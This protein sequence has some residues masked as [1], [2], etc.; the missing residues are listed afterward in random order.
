[1]KCSSAWSHPPTCVMMAMAT[2]PYSRCATAEA[3]ASG[4]VRTSDIIAPAATV[5]ASPTTAFSCKATL[6]LIAS[7]SHGEITQARPAGRGLSGEWRL[8]SGELRTADCYLLTANLL[9]W[10]SRVTAGFLERRERVEHFL[11]RGFLLAIAVR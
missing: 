6:A 9:G 11:A 3:T 5:L 8:G 1:M 4:R 7:S 2:A 10:Q